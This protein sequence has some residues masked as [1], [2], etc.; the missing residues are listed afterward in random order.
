[1][2][3]EGGGGSIR[4]GHWHWIEIKRH[5]RDVTLLIDQRATSSKKTPG[6]F[7]S[8][9]FYKDKAEMYIGGGPMV[10]WTRSVSKRNFSGLLQQLHV[11]RLKVL[12]RARASNHNKEYR[13]IGVVLL[14]GEASTLWTTHLVTTP[15][16]SSGGNGS[17]CVYDVEGLCKTEAI[18]SIPGEAVHHA[19]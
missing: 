18:V 9:D 5:K 7:T 2:E 4:D 12:D 19:T 11:G 14:G 16:P 3:L 13:K 10:E 6:A 8:L 17:G 1:M 15:S